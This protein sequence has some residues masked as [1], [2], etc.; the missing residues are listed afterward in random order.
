[1]RRHSDICEHKAC[2]WVCLLLALAIAGIGSMFTGG[3]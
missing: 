2:A 3:V 1:M